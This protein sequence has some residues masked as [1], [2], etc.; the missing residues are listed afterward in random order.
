M[1]EATLLVVGDELLA[2]EIE[3]RN[4][5]FFSRELAGH[6]VRSRELRVLPD[7]AAV[8]ADAV[9]AALAR[10]P[11]VLIT[12]GLGP[13]SDDVTTE[14]VA[15]ALGRPLV[16]DAQSWERIRQ[17]FARRGI[18]PPEGNE[19][20]AMFPEGAVILPNELGTA[21][22]YV[23]P[24]D[25]GHPSDHPGFV[26]VLPGPPRENRPMLRQALLPW[27][28]R[29]VLAGVPPL[30]TVVLRSFGLTESEIGHRLRPLEAR[31][32]ALQFGYQLRFPEIL[33]KLRA[34]AAAGPELE[35][36][37]AEVEAACAP[38]LYARGEERLPE[39]LGRACAARHL[40]IVTAES[41]TGGLAAKLLTDTPGSSDWFERGFVTYSNE[42]KM[43]LLGVPAGLLAAHGAVSEPV[44]EAMLQGALARSAADIGL[45]IT[46]IA[47]PGG[48]SEAKPV[49]T[50]CL[51]WGGRDR[52]SVR[53]YGFAP[54]DRGGVRQISAWT[55][56][57]RLWLE[58]AGSLPE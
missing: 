1:M 10:S 39:L 45:A 3:D 41:C 17:S 24:V 21:P 47:G 35:Q 30:K 34:D 54:W 53:T 28:T 50:V 38:H 23:V 58:L 32:P 33:V 12:G 55:G 40:R 5:P 4:G 48:G 22:G 44:A 20:Q 8:V 11:A 56:F 43:E 14:A 51:A 9:R 37:A 36:A 49:G 19:K 27:L 16:R 52:R 31:H 29:H 13:T 18:E 26:A 2:G 15:A 6:G 57:F 7:D 25:R 46:G 42:A